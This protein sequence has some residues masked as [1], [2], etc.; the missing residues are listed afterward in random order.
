MVF[1]FLYFKTTKS[2]CNFRNYLHIYVSMYVCMYTLALR[3]GGLNWCE[4]SSVA[5]GG[6]R[7]SK[8][9]EHMAHPEGQHH[10][11]MSHLNPTHTGVRHRT[12]VSKSSRKIQSRAFSL[13]Q[14]KLLTW[15]QRFHSTVPGKCPH[16]ILRNARYM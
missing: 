5:R 14:L 12:F 1:F 9:K 8:T 16:N 6:S 13:S 10:W 11:K 2:L 7:G 15:A 3:F 4:W